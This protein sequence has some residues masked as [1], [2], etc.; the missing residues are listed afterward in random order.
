[1]YMY[2]YMYMYMCMC[3][4]LIYCKKVHAFPRGA[5]QFKGFIIHADTLVGVIGEFLGR[6]YHVLLIN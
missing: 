1:M 4:F 2:V 3:P 5:T 6:G